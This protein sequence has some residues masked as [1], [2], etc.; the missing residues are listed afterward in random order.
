M[1][2]VLSPKR[3]LAGKAVPVI[4]NYQTNKIAQPNTSLSLPGKEVIWSCSDW[5]N[6]HKGLVKFFMEGRFKSKIRYA[7][8]QAIEQANQVYMQHWERNANF[9]SS[10]RM[11]GYAGEF[12]SYFKSVGLTDVLSI[13]QAIVVPTTNT[14]VNVVDTTTRTIEKT[15]DA[16]GKTIVNAGDALANTTGIAKYAIPVAV[17]GAVFLVGAYLYKN[18]VKGNKRVKV[19]IAKI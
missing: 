7:K 11:C 14:T 8:P 16:A 4:F 18:Y 3:S 13:L 5:M 6:F 19:G 9:W 15:A 10:L 12:Y 2:L 1:E 17:G